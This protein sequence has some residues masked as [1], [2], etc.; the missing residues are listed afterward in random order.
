MRCVLFN[1]NTK[2]LEAEYDE[3]IGAFIEIYAIYNID[4][5]PYILSTSYRKNKDIKTSL[6]K[7]FNKRGIPSWRDWLD[8]LLHRLNIDAPYELLDKAFA[9]SLSDQYWLKPTGLDLKYDDINF[10]DNDFDYGEF[11]EASL[12][13]EN[14]IVKNEASLKTPNNTTDGMLKKA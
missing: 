9:L 12:S 2:I 13:K 14:K 4:Y 7:W 1:K 5:A 10:F 8:V 11:L 6:N 3:T